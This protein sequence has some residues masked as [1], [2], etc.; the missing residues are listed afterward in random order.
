MSGW[1]HGKDD[2]IH[3]A[4]VDWTQEVLDLCQN[5]G[6]GLEPHDLDRGIPG[7]FNACHAEKQLVAYFIY[8]H[9]ILP[10]ETQQPED[11]PLDEISLS[12]L[13]LDD[14]PISHVRE[15]RQ[16]EQARRDQLRERA[17]KLQALQEVWPAAFLREAWILVSR[18]ACHDCQ[19]FVERVNGELGL[20]I[21]VRHCMSL[22]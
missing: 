2:T 12:R 1:S 5:I 13:T 6:F 15:R 21:Q 20:R 8:K 7:R 3:V 19:R 10:T 22:D 4:G 17:S 18:E 11:D 9:L 14:W 16:R